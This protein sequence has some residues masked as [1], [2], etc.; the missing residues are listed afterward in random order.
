[1]KITEDTEK[2]QRHITTQLLVFFTLAVIGYVLSVGPVLS[3]A[4]R[5]DAYHTPF[6]KPLR[7]FYSPVF[8]VAK[9]SDA[10]TH[11]YENY[12]RMWCRIVLPPG[13]PGT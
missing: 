10:T 7:A 8:A 4:E 1:M 12:A 9:S 6:Y 11:L 5:F 2:R 3:V 13:S